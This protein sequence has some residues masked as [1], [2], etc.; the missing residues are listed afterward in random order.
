MRS[1]FWFRRDLRLRD[2]P[3]LAEAARI[4][5]DV[6][7]V[8]V[9]DPGLL[10]SAGPARR[11]FLADALDDLNR[12]LGGALH[13]TMGDPAEVL[14]SLAAGL[15]VSAVVATGDHTPQARRRDAAVAA[16]LTSIGVESRYVDTPTLGAPG[17]YRNGSGQPFK[18]FT[19]YFKAAALTHVPEPLEPISA[20]WRAIPSTVDPHV[21]LRPS[22]ASTFPVSLVDA[23]PPTALPRGGETAALHRLEQ[24]DAVVDTYDEQ[25]NFPAL[26]TTSRLSADLH[27]GCLHPRQVIA[28]IAGPSDGRKAFIRQLYWREFYADV[29]AENPRTAHEDL[30]PN[31]VAV[32]SGPIA[33]ER[34]I[35]WALG[36]TG[37]PMVDAGMRQLLTEGWMHNRVRMLTA[38]FLIKDLH[39]DWRWGAAWF[40][41]RLVDGDVANNIHGWQWTAGVGTDASP[42][43]RVFNPTLQAERFDPDGT[44]IRR[45]VPE[46]ASITGSA[47]L[48]PGGGGAGGLFSNGYFEPMVDHA[49][50]REEALGR[51]ERSRLRS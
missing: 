42:Y 9:F 3:A 31:G 43:Y 11:A 24:F 17:A 35:A 22:Q 40:M 14:S 12:Q 26:D 5:T 39:L 2:N 41:W 38:S 21:V 48:Q 18:V 51:L 30:N 34:F 45:Y 23:P 16:A 50:E 44:Y 6:I 32:D 10:A 7:P 25:R 20:D 13:I 28:Q 4:S 33:N 37:Y 49:A 29:L 27:F 1:I 15:G 47:V 8:F 46:L 19:P 36:R